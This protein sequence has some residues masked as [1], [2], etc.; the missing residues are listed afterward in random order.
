MPQLDH[1]SGNDMIEVVR[2]EEASQFSVSNVFYDI[3]PWQRGYVAVIGSSELLGMPAALHISAAQLLLRAEL[4]VVGDQLDSLVLDELLVH[5]SQRLQD[6]FLHQDRA[7]QISLFS[8]GDRISLAMAVVDE[9]QQLLRCA[10][11]GEHAAIWSEAARDISPS[12]LYWQHGQVVYLLANANS[13]RQPMKLR[14]THRSQGGI[15]N[16]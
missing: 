2:E 4:D 16:G 12:Q 1:F 15:A 7:S 11:L 10:T 5:Y 6:M 14:I 13:D 3:I 8:Q 9:Q